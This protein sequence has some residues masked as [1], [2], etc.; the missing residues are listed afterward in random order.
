[1]IRRGMTLTKFS[2]FDD[3]GSCKITYFNQ[4]YIKDSIVQG[5]TYRFYGR[6]K[7]TG[8][9]VSMAS[10]IA[11]PAG[12]G[13]RLLPLSPLYPLTAG[14]S[15]KQMRTAVSGALA[16]LLSP[17]VK[18]GIKET[19]PLELRR[20]YSLC[21]IGYALRGIHF[22]D[23]FETLDIARRRLVFDDLYTF[24]LLSRISDR[25]SVV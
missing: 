15:Q 19:L 11:E 16:L 9:G 24:A 21:D 10:P 12:D 14:I 18:N 2:A 5:G 1:M 23:S 22:P 20:R 25:K 6:V 13:A 7:R 4:P 3:T 8:T 17:V